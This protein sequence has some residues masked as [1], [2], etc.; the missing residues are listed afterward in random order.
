[1]IDY[2]QIL[3]LNYPSSQW[4]LNGDSYDGL[5]WLSDTQKPTQE[6]LDALWESTQAAV[7]A[8]QQAKIAAKEAALSKLTALGLTADEVKA[9][10]GA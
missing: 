9:L 10:L 1:M 2:T 8:K 6:E 5:T 3:I 4:T 7:A